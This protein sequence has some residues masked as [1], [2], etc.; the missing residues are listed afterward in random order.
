MYDVSGPEPIPT[1]PR[2]G[3]EEHGVPARAPRGD[4]ERGGAHGGHADDPGAGD[5]AQI[6]GVADKELTPAA[7]AALIRLLGEIERLRLELAV[8][9]N[10][11]VWL[12]RLADRDGHLPVLNRRAFMR[13]TTRVLHRVR[14][15]RTPAAL[16]LVEIAGLDRIRREH[17]LAAADAALTQVATVLAG[18]ADTNDPVG[19]AGTQTF[20]VVIVGASA[21]EGRALVSRWLE[22]LPGG[23]SRL[24]CLT[25]ASEL[26]GDGDAIAMIAAADGAMR[27]AAGAG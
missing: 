25:G 20:G 8:K 16:V 11:E 17:G 21:A 27:A 10:H 5:I 26:A 12:E 9:S 2:V 7:R 23:T 6:A 14:R 22:H 1:I 18:A 3:R 24:A 4:G 13:E 15:S 19:L